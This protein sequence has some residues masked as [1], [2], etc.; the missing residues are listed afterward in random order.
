M[1]RKSILQNGWTALINAAYSGHVDCARLL[2]DA[3]ADKDAKCN[4]RFAR[5]FAEV[6]S[7][8]VFSL[9]CL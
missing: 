6:G 3:G 9:H 2:I 7:D 8:L 5:C 1:L 4:V